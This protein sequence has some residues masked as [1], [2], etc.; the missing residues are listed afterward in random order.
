LNGSHHSSKSSPGFSSLGY[1]STLNGSSTRLS[2]T[3]S[4]KSSTLSHK[5]SAAA[6]ELSQQQQLD[7][8]AYINVRTLAFGFPEIAVERAYAVY[9]AALLYRQDGVAAVLHAA[10]AAAA[11][12]QILWQ[13]TD[14]PQ[15]LTGKGLPLQ[16][17]QQQLMVVVGVLK[18]VLLATFAAAQSLTWLA[19][20]CHFK[21]RQQRARGAGV[22]QKVMAAVGRLVYC[23]EL[24][25]VLAPGVGLMMVYGCMYQGGQ[26][27]AALQQLVR[28]S[29]QF[30]L[31]LVGYVALAQPLISA[32]RLPV[33]AA[34]SVTL[35]LL[36]SKLPDSGFVPGVLSPWLEQQGAVG[37]VAMVALTVAG[38]QEARMQGKF[39]RAVQGAT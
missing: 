11:F 38:L 20:W 36:Q 22:W 18:V 9:K 37:V 12:G 2:N 21:H 30:Q 5:L 17:Q 32:A 23:R 10:V 27:A 3:A 14:L 35:V 31:F 39:I 7:P 4:S 1:G 25:M 8:A 28:N 16:Q 33:T 34:N 29:P 15:A 13:L 6:A 24:L 19:T 26:L